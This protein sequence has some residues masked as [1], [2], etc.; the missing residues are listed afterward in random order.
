MMHTLQSALDYL[1]DALRSSAE[2]RMRMDIAMSSD[3]PRRPEIMAAFDDQDFLL[4]SLRSRVAEYL[5]SHGH[6]NDSLLA[7]LIYSLVDAIQDMRH[8]RIYRIT[9]GGVV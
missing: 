5:E 3:D 8:E 2:F 1:E 7:D 6:E 9:W 4:D